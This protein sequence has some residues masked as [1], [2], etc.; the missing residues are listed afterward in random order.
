VRGI[1]CSLRTA[2]LRLIAAG[3]YRSGPGDG[4][5]AS[6]PPRRGVVL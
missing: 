1:I 6:P 2:D 5:K 4:P 3:R